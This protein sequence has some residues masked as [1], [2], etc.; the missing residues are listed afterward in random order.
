MHLRRVVWII[1]NLQG[2]GFSKGQ[3]AA[4]ASG[5]G[6]SDGFF[7]GIIDFIPG[8]EFEDAIHDFEAFVAHR[9]GMRLAD[10]AIAQVDSADGCACFVFHQFVGREGKVVVIK[11]R[12]APR[13]AH[14]DGESFF[15]ARPH[16]ISRGDGEVKRVHFVIVNAL[17]LFQTQHV[18]VD[19]KAAVAHG[20]GESVFIIRINGFEEANFGMVFVAVDDAGR[21]GDIGRRVIFVADRHGGVT[22][23]A[24]VVSGSIGKGDFDGDLLASFRF[25]QFVGGFVRTLDF[26]TVGVPAVTDGFGRYLDAFVYAQCA[27]I[28]IVHFGSEDFARLGDTVEV[29]GRFE[30]VVGDGVAFGIAV[31]DVAAI[32]AVVVHGNA[33]YRAD[34]VTQFN[35]VLVVERVIFRH[36]VLLIDGVV[37]DFAAFDTDVAHADMVVLHLVVFK[38]DIFH[39]GSTAVQM[40][41]GNETGAV[42][43]KG[44]V[45]HYHVTDLFVFVR[46][47]VDTGARI[48]AVGIFEDGVLDF[49]VLAVG[50][51]HPLTAVMLGMYLLKGDVFVVDVA[52]AAFADVEAV[53][54]AFFGRHVFHRHIGGISDAH[55]VPPFAVFS[56]MGGTVAFDGAT[57]EVDV[58]G[59]L[60]GDNGGILGVVGH[61]FEQGCARHAQGDVALHDETAGFEVRAFLMQGVDEVSPIWDIDD[62]AT[63][64]GDGVNGFLDGGGIIRFTVTFGAESGIL[65]VNHSAAGR[66]FHR[67]FA[68]RA[69]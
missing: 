50:D 14:V 29:H 22:G 18:A 7:L 44:V 57:N 30:V 68:I 4:I 2:E 46:L 62:T 27:V 16:L 39:R 31:N 1:L 67:I 11:G 9:V 21:E 5:N 61:R 58:V 26:C 51:G 35:A 25:R 41:H 3:A 40:V 60:D 66:C 55:T 47:N 45:S 53:T 52:A 33:G 56:G 48:S 8:F 54:P 17:A 42:A 38:G 69:G 23:G 36:V 24:F 15:V 13:R 43:N 10:T 65:D 12:G 37:P 34:A 59:V 49:D 64:G 20:V 19:F 28:T 6:D 32:D 63:F